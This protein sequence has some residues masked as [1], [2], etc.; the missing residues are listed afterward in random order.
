MDELE[1]ALPNEH[2]AVLTRKMVE[3]ILDQL[4]LCAVGRLEIA[5]VLQRADLY[6]ES[7]GRCGVQQKVDALLAE[8]HL[9]AG[10]CAGV[11]VEK[12]EFRFAEGISDRCR[13]GS[14]ITP[15]VRSYA[16]FSLVH[17]GHHAAPNMTHCG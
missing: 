2:L 17:V 8:I 5:V 4:N 15:S 16:I 3:A 14:S 1:H 6:E 11:L 10:Q 9:E 12:F 13:K 7:F